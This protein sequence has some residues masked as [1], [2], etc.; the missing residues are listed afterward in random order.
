[1]RFASVG[2]EPIS[3]SGSTTGTSG[4]PR[5]TGRQAGF[6]T[7]RT[8]RPRRS[9][10]ARIGGAP[11]EPCAR[12]RRSSPPARESTTSRC[13]SRAGRSSRSNASSG[14]DII[15]AQLDGRRA[16]ALARG[17]RAR[18]RLLRGQED[19]ASSSTTRSSTR[20]RR[21]TSRSA[22][23]SRTRLGDVGRAAADELLARGINVSGVHTDF[24]IGGPEVEVDGL[25]RRRRS[26][27]DPPRRRLAARVD[28]CRGVWLQPD[29]GVR[30][31]Q[32][33]QS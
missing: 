6:G 9:S 13:A 26:D 27:A 21:A 18:R 1:M 23:A 29:S 22:A 31:A 5:R 30:P 2:Q 19:R 17:G 32:P 7:C 25:D 15:R 33:V 12:P 14:A 20:T 24:M 10:R 11:R 4:A 28:R 3:R 8:S 16:G